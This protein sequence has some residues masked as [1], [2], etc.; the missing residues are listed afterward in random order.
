[1]RELEKYVAECLKKKRGPKPKQNKLMPKPGKDDPS[2]SKKDLDK[3]DPGKHRGKKGMY[4]IQSKEV[5]TPLAYKDRD[6]SNNKSS[7]PHSHIT[8]ACYQTHSYSTKTTTKMLQVATSVLVA[9]TRAIRIVIPIQILTLLPVVVAQTQV[10]QLQRQSL[11]KAH[12]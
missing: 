9:L 2:Q 6:D 3:R 7:H 10:I 11:F 4:M 8:N 5:C 12:H 1:M